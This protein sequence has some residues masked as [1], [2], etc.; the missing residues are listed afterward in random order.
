MHAG[1]LEKRE[2]AREVAPRVASGEALWVLG[3]LVTFKVRAPG[4]TIL[5]A[6]THPGKAPP[7]FVHHAQDTLM[8][9][10][11]GEYEVSGERISAGSYAFIPKDTLHSV[12]VAGSRPG[13]CL[14]ILTPP[15]PA[16]SFFEEVG[17]PVAN[18]S[19]FELPEK[20]TPDVERLLACARRHGIELLLTPV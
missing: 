12:A 11:E 5:E 1:R 3:S 6:A 9:I 2:A 15:G 16:E 10:L 19:S 7:P 14:V 13:R 17:V 20:G 4:C 8:L 18:G